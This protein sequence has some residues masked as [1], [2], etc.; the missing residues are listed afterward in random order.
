MAEQA[1][2]AAKEA[3]QEQAKAAEKVY[4]FKSSKK[5]L[6]CAALGVQFINGVAKTSNLEVARALAK[7][8]GVE[9]V[10]K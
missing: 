4:T 8:D 9:L 1:K 3:E 2:A 5:F 7:I 10:E 6:S